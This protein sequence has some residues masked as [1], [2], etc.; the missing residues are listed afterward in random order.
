MAISWPSATHFCDSASG[1]GNGTPGAP[2]TPAEA[3]ANVAAG[4]VVFWRGASAYQ[5]GSTLAFSTSGTDAAPIWLIGTDYA[6]APLTIGHV[7]VD[8]NGGAYHALALSGSHMV[9][10]GIYGSGAVSPQAGIRIDG[11]SITLCRCKAE[12]G[13]YAFCQVSASYGVTYYDCEA[14][15]T[16]SGMGF[17]DSY[18]PAQYLGCVA[19]GATYGF[20]PQGPAALVSCRAYDIGSIGVRHNR[21]N[22][23]GGI[24]LI[25]HGSFYDC[26]NAIEIEGATY[27]NSVLITNNIFDTCSAYGVKLDGVAGQLA[28]VLNNGYRA[29]TSGNINDSG[30]TGLLHG[31]WLALPAS[32]FV[33]AAGGDLSLIRSTPAR[34][35]A[36]DGGDLGAMQR[37]IARTPH[38]IAG[39]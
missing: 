6:W 25:D 35:A 11:D 15:G 1:G 3:A 10:A 14:H 4:N 39:L 29:C 7:E 18:G 5:K 36:L 30:K 9:V 38:P 8:A 17:Y 32:P 20:V 33:N 2:W 31:N 27:A 19:H 21:D 28:T 13:Y 26:V 12:V 23:N 34:G 16:G 24:C 37:G 22:A